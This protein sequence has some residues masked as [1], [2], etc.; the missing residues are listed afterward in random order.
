MF[1]IKVYFA[2]FLIFLIIDDTLLFSINGSFPICT[3]NN[4]LFYSVYNCNGYS[5]II[6]RSFCEVYMNFLQNIESDDDYHYIYY[7]GTKIFFY[8]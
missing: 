6:E 8:K 3:Q 5:D 4:E 7:N 2:L 1:N